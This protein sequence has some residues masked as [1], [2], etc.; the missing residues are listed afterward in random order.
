MPKK[1]STFKKLSLLLISIIFITFLSFLLSNSS[2]A[3]GLVPESSSN[4]SSCSG[5]SATECGD[6]K[7]N[8]FLQLAVNIA[9]WILGIVGVLTLVMFIFGGISFI[10]SAG[11]KEQVSKAKK[12]I[13][14]A[15]VGLIIV[16]VSWLV[17][18]FLLKTLTDKNQYY[19][20]YKIEEIIKN[21]E[22][23]YS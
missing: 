7:I 22:S 8:D 20:G 12:I 6:Y 10:F 1:I 15:I 21:Y 17:I 13:I 4:E 11:S 9:Q 5:R 3:Q 2:F 23:L 14:S 19:L 18:N 16:F